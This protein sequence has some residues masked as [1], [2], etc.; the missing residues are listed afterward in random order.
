MTEPWSCRAKALSPPPR[1]CTRRLR[2]A[3]GS[4]G[5]GSG[6]FVSRALPAAGRATIPR[7]RPSMLIGATTAGHT[8]RYREEDEPDARERTRSHAQG[9]QPGDPRT[10]APLGTAA[11]SG[12]PGSR[13]RRLSPG[14]GA[15]GSVRWPVVA[16]RGVPSSGA[17][18]CARGTAGREGDADA[19]DAPSR[20][21]T[22][23]RD[24][25]LSGEG[26][27][28]P[29]LRSEAVTYGARVTPAVRA[30]LADGPRTRAEV[31]E[32]LETSH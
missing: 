5:L 27:R 17:R 13:A 23:L 22:R 29:V 7:A 4:S 30:F 19:R 16:A 9:A 14:P 26:G 31:F 25:P 10:P 1:R 21:A 2:R 12:G 28:S 15:A 3:G 11:A 32:L 18:S 24:V 8:L 20:F 6:G